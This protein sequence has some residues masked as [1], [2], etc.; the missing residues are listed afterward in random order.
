MEEHTNDF[1]ILPLCSAKSIVNLL[2]KNWFNGKAIMSTTEQPETKA[3][4]TEK[5]TKKILQVLL[6]KCDR[7]NRYTE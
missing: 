7:S 5:E 2:F 1:D 6:T 3:M 4:I